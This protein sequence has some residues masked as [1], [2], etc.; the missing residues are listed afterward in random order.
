[1][2]GVRVAEHG[3]VDGD[4][5]GVVVWRVGLEGRGE[6]RVGQ[7]AGEDGGDFGG[8]EARG[9]RGVADL[10]VGAPVAGAGVGGGDGVAEVAAGADDEDVV[11]GGSHGCVWVCGW[12]GEGG[13]KGRRSER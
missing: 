1:M 2:R 11:G 3:V 12:C 8:G 5:D 7:V 10:A 13:G 6:V 4:D 9:V